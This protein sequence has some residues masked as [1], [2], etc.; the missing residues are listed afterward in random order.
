[1]SAPRTTIAVLD[2]D[3]T[4]SQTVAD[5][6]L[7]LRFE[8][9]DVAWALDGGADLVFALTNSRALPEAQAIALNRALAARLAAAARRRGRALRLVSRS[10]STLR[11]HFPAEVLAIV[12]GLRDAGAEPP[13]AVLLCPA[14]PEAGRVTVGGVHYVRRD[15]TLVP[16]AETE[17]AR[18]PVFG[19]RDSDLRAWAA[20]RMDVAR[21]EVMHVPLNDVRAG[22]ARIAQRLREASGGRIVVLDAATHEDLQLLARG[23][24]AAERDGQRF[25]CR[26]GPSFVAPLAGRSVP[27]PI[28][29]VA[30]RPGPGLVVVGSHTAITT[31]QLTYAVEHH[32]LALVEISTTAVADSRRRERELARV[33]REV[34]AALREGDVALATSRALLRAESP[35]ASAKLSATVSAALVAAVRRIA[36][37]VQLAFLVAKGGITAHDLAASALGAGRATVAGQ[38]FPGQVSVWRLHESEH[39]EMPFVVFPGNVGNVDA[40]AEVIGR[41]RGDA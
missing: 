9:D 10:D 26:T 20:D 18:D 11:G 16:V 2:D 37:D 31:R 25:L 7:L 12:D 14:F 41:L 34:A 39:A 5:V 38:V 21:A 35:A 28:A 33:V 15:G 4:G 40:L 30:P 22:V 29:P 32:R 24:V 8:E 13:D 23:V 6:P 1:M 19:Y 3:P 27:K 36:A 17:F